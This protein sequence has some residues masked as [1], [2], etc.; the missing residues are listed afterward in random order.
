MPRSAIL[1]RMKT[2]YETF[3]EIQPF[4]CSVVIAAALLACGILHYLKGRYDL[5]PGGNR[6]M[7]TVDTNDGRVLEGYRLKR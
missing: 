1:R 2:K 6:A 4:V 5:K 3:V 7:I